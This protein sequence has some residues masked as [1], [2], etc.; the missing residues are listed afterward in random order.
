MLHCTPAAADVLRDVR[1]ERGIPDDFGLRVAAGASE[2][3]EV[4]LHLGF[5]EEPMEGDQ[6]S[7]AHGQRLFVAPDV[8]AGLSGMAIDVTGDAADGA[9]RELVLRPAS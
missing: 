8:A 3:G 5:T 2:G 4:S 6:V 1:Q 7:D 9:P